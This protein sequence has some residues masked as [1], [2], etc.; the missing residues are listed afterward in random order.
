MVGVPMAHAAPSPSVASRPPR[1]STS[2]L[3]IR[4]RAGRDLVLRGVDLSG[5]EYTPTDQALPYDAADFATI[6]ATGATVVRLPISWAL[7]EPT[8]GV[9]DPAA[10]ARVAQIVEW[11]GQA[12]LMVVLDMH[13]Y[14]WTRCFGGLGVPTWA[15]PNC[16]ATPPSNPAEVFTDYATAETW[17][18]AH[19]AL[20]AALADT[21]AAVAQAVGH[22]KNL[23]GYDL[24]NEPGISFIPPEVFEEQ[25]LVPFYRMVGT[26]LRAVDPGGLIFVEPSV[27]NGLVNGSSQFLGPIGLPGVVFAPHQYG[28]DSLNPDTSGNAYDLAGPDQF[29]LDLSIDRSVAE[30]MGAAEWLGEWGAITPANSYQPIAYIN[31]DLAAQDQMMLGSAYWSYS[32]NDSGGHF[33]PAEAGA[34]TRISPLAIGGTPDS[35]AT[36]GAGLSMS[37][38]ADNQTTVVSL[39]SGCQPAV[40]VTSGTAT[41]HVRPGGWLDVRAPAG[42]AVSIQVRCA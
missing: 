31:D 26:R 9:F 12:G 41:S 42:T 13:Q 14:D 6:R 33:T 18:W 7:L 39:P 22:P 37:W 2:G 40:E 24:F 30:R 36:G 23:L 19:P 35:F 38:V 29:A 27:A 16:P 10:L 25:Y 34:L 1:F 3:W 4:D 8:P 20:Q 5:A 21:W 28:L 11:A 17:F 32:H 15:V